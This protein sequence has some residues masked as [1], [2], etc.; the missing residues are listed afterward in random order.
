MNFQNCKA[1]IRTFCAS[2]DTFFSTSGSARGASGNRR[3]F[4]GFEEIERIEKLEDWFKCSCYVLVFCA[5]K[6]DDSQRAKSIETSPLNSIP[7]S[8]ENYN[9][10]YHE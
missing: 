10:G 8:G 5:E 4:R 6:C 1:S 2:D 9:G 7:V 3:N